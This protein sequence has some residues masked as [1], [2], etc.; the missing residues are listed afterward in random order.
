MPNGRRLRHGVLCC[1]PGI[2]LIDRPLQSIAICYNLSMHI[3][4]HARIVEAQARFPECAAALDAWYRLMK[5]G[6][7]KNFAELR[8]AFGNVDRV[9]PL[10]VFNVGG[11]KLRIIAAIHFNTGKVFVRH[12]LTHEEYDREAWKRQEG[13]Q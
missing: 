10:Y 3:I 8:A 7:F 2:R 13:R 12:V 6:R 11:N 9:K 1:C 4:T 5:R